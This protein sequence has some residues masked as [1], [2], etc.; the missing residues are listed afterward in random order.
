MS[1]AVRTF[2][3]I[4]V[5]AI[6]LGGA[7]SLR[8]G[9]ETNA[10]DSQSH[11]VRI[12]LAGDSTVTDKA[13]WGL[14]FARCLGTNA[15]CINLSK[16]GRSS[17][18][19]IGEGS[20]RQCLELKPDYVI[21]QFG[22]NDQPGHG[23]R[24]TEPETT[25]KKFMTQFVEDARAAG[26]KPVL[27]TP[28]SRRQWGED[29]RI[30]STLQPWVEVVKEIATEKKVPLIDLHQ[31][32]IEMYER[33][34]QDRILEISPRRNADSKSTNSDTA[35]AQNKGFD[36]THLNP[37]GSDMVGPI[38]AEELRKAV[39]ALVGYFR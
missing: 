32:S 21:I 24:E 2:L 4:L 23:D 27:V 30:H 29:G 25:Y 11:R 18:S 1:V 16:G 12:V 35:S 8:A 26:L 7:G 36:G 28:L 38:V 5:V 39:P 10:L 34:G 13:G 15:E 22:H 31:R 33:M 17:K 6:S 3:K 9:L 14:G 19:Y 20:W 37:K